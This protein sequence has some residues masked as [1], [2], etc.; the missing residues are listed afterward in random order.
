MATLLSQVE[1]MREYAR[2]CPDFVMTKWL[3]R[4]AIE[5]C[6]Q[7][8][9]YRETII[10]PTVAETEFYDLEASNPNAEVFGIQA[11][12]FKGVPLT[13]GAPE[14]QPQ[15]DGIPRYFW[16]LPTQEIALTPTTRE[17]ADDD[18]AVNVLLK[19]IENATELDD[20]LLREF[21]EAIRAG[22]LRRILTMPKTAWR[23]DNE[24]SNQAAIE[25]RG[26]DNARWKAD[27]Q[28]RTADFVT[29]PGF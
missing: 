8:R 14:E 15:V 22:A 7:T 17:D 9:Y 6:H 19:P 26:H 5:F 1:Y 2:N 11:A 29:L 25:R 28:H 12:E 13:Q 10:V 27:T 16:Y 23:D 20:E 24:A 4:S 3:L 18:L 21:G